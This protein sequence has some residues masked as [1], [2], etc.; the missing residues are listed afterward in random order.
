MAAQIRQD[1]V[2]TRL[3]EHP[4]PRNHVLLLVIVIVEQEK[5][6]PIPDR[7]GWGTVVFRKTLKPQL[8]FSIRNR[9]HLRGHFHP[10]IAIRHLNHTQFCRRR[11]H[12]DETGW[13]P[14]KDFGKCIWLARAQVWRGHQARCQRFLV[15]TGRGQALRFPPSQSGSQRVRGAGLICERPDAPALEIHC[16]FGEIESDQVPRQKPQTDKVVKPTP[17]VLHY[18]QIRI[19]LASPKTLGEPGHSV[20]QDQVLL[21]QFLLEQSRIQRA[22][23]ITAGIDVR[24]RAFDA[25]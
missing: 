15:I 18:V 19:G 21:P 8:S 7:R 23:E 11:T 4:G 24:L 20:G 9:Y 16:A 10:V 1:D 5:S 6:S 13:V 3:S 12:R 25:C 2:V 17:A 22:I 14:R